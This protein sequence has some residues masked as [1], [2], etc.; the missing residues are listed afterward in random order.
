MKG[1][2]VSEQHREE[3]QK[4][5]EEGEKKRGREKRMGRLGYNDRKVEKKEKE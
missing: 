4:G 2:K 3:K 1:K 5:S